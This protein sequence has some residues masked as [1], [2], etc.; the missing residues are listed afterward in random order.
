[1]FKLV[2]TVLALMPIALDLLSDMLTESS[3]HLLI[4]DCTTG[5][6]RLHSTGCR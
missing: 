6:T 2:V 3:S 1:M 4:H 5:S